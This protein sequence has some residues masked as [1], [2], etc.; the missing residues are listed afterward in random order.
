[1]KKL[2]SFFSAFIL[3]LSPN[4]M[5]FA[6]SKRE[7][8]IDIGVNIFAINLRYSKEISPDRDFFAR[9]GLG[10]VLFRSDVH[11]TYLPQDSNSSLGIDL[12]FGTNNYIHKNDDIEND[13]KFGTYIKTFGGLSTS[14]ISPTF[15]SY[16]YIGTGIGLNYSSGLFGISLGIDIGT[17]LQITNEAYFG[18]VIFTR[19][20]INTRWTF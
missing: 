7:N 17:T 8:A 3:I 16:P 4:S 12:E 1:M 11:G 18:G 14:I 6:D 2:I 10:I 19:P 15:L 9:T 20:E 5:C 13:K